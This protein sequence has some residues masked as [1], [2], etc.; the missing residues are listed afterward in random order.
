MRYDFSAMFD[1][2][3][4]LGATPVWSRSSGTCAI[5]AVIATRGSPVRSASPPTRTAPAVSGRMPVTASASSR[6]PLP[7][8]PAIP[9]TSPARTDNETERSGLLAAVARR[10]EPVDLEDHLADRVLASRPPRHV[11]VA[12]DHQRGEGL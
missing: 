6:W 7:A 10:R 11:D 1:A 9:S 2:M 5:P 3:L 8:T 4:R 12:A